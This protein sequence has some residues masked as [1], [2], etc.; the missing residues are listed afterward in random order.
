MTMP[1]LLAL[2]A[3]AALGWVSGAWLAQLHSLRR[4]PAS[5]GPTWKRHRDVA[6]PT[7]GRARP[8]VGT[9]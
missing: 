4:P 5:L 3:G 1:D 2:L 6:V 7:F 8:K 9:P